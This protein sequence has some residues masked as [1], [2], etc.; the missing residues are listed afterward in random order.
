[1]RARASPEANGLVARGGRSDI[2]TFSTRGAFAGIATGAGTARQRAEETE[3]ANDAHS[4]VE[5]RGERQALDG[6]NGPAHAIAS[7]RIR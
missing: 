3:M 5:V 4:A 6:F 7:S 1:V 2:A